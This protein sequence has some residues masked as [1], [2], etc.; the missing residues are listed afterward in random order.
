MKM[1]NKNFYILL[2]FCTMLFCACEKNEVEVET[3]PE[4]LGPY[5]SLADFYAQN[6][7]ASQDTIVDPTQPF[8]IIGA[9]GLEIQV[10][11]N[12][13]YD[14]NGQQATGLV[15]VTLKEIYTL[16]DMVLSHI[17]TT[18]NGTMLE[19][20]GMFNI[21]FYSNAVHYKAL[22]TVISMPAVIALPGMHIYNG[23]PDSDI[24]INWTISPDTIANYVIAD[25]TGINPEY[26]LT[27]DSLGGW[28][29][30]AR[31]YGGAVT[32]ISVATQVDAWRGETVDVALYTLIPIKNICINVDNF[33]G[34]QTV[35]VNSLPNGMNAY[36]AA[37]GVGRISKKSYFG[38][39]NFTVTAG[40]TVT[41]NLTQ[42]DAEIATALQPL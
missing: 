27:V 37:I 41:I 34:S 10:P 38:L 22:F 20:D 5:Q 36:A 33:S 9:G 13:L 18:A 4:A 12:S 1:K 42:A 11:G 14:S 28:I 19:W 3:H 23:A 21:D 31:P 30:C 35:A 40:Q 6:D 7:V 24:G 8:S 32:N 39:V 2:T 16:K 25:S 29:N 26:F 17:P 15:T